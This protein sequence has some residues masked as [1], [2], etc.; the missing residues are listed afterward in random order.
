MIWSSE[1]HL[2]NT[3]V[4]LFTE[5]E[6]KRKWDREREYKEGKRWEWKE[7][8]RLNAELEME[9]DEKGQRG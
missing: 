9:T 6:V 8:E 4:G 5:P 2:W 1:T 3:K 7:C